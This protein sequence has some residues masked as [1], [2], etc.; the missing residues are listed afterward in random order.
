MKRTAPTPRVSTRYRTATFGFLGM[1]ILIAGAISFVSFTKSTITVTLEH[2]TVEKILSLAVS[3]TPAQEQGE[4]KGTVLVT[5][6]EDSVSAEVP[7]NG[8]TVDDYAHGTVTIHNK[9]N[10]PQ[11]LAA[12]TRLKSLVNG[13]IYR[14][15][16]RTDV[17]VGGSV[18]VEIVADEVGERGNVGP[19]TFEIVALW[20]GLKDKIYA[21]N[22][23]AFTGGTRS[24]SQLSQ[25][26]IDEATRTLEQ[27]LLKKAGETLPAIPDDMTL[28]GTPVPLT[29]HY[30]PNAKAGDSVTT[31]TVSGTLKAAAVAV[32]SAIAQEL[33][34][35]SA[36]ELLS[37]DERYLDGNPIPT[38]RVLEANEREKTAQVELTLSGNVRLSSDSTV[39][40][41]SRFVRMTAD[42]VRKTLTGTPGVASVSVAI[43][44][45]WAS[46]CPSLASQ[47]KVVATQPKAQ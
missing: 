28:V 38:W 37:K 14:T 13:M 24:S 2:R 29:P 3:H 17:P 23:T 39:L 22:D 30:A 9:W 18:S 32:N 25:A 26:T 33:L 40:A 1:V 19:G 27:R 41:P 5:T 36:S 6:V 10:K 34:A 20:P 7:R 47:I 31:I 35:A 44:P 43:S 12:T 46:R 42:D 16:T 21:E 15:K 11:P 8:A 45:F 4:L